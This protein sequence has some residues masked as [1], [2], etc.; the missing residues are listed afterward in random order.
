MTGKSPP[1]SKIRPGS[2]L[3][4]LIPPVEDQRHDDVLLV[5]E[6]PGQ[7]RHEPFVLVGLTVGSETLAVGAFLK[8]AHERVGG[9]GIAL[10]RLM[11]A[12]VVGVEDVEAAL[13]PAFCARERGKIVL[14]L[15]LVMAFEIAEEK[16]EAR[17]EPGGEGGRIQP[18]LAVIGNPPGE[19]RADVTKH[20]VA[21]QPE[22]RHA[23]D[24][25]MRLPL[26]ARIALKQEPQILGKAGAR[27]QRE[28]VVYGLNSV[29]MGGRG[30]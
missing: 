2:G 16:V 29:C 10:E 1:T 15:D 12:V 6:M 27:V 20:V 28:R 11:D 30:L 22:L 9:F 23:A 5:L 14:I 24:V 18:A 21:L 25:V 3:Q 17:R 8:R 19:H 13:Q 7:E 26:G 4:R